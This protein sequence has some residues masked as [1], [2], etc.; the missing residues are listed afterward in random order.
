MNT[1]FY[2]IIYC[3]K[4]H[5]CLKTSKNVLLNCGFIVNLNVIITGMISHSAYLS[6]RKYH[7]TIKTSLL[8]L[9]YTDHHIVSY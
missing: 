8:I 6:E 7:C 9:P 2:T 4:V 1:T 5:N 3:K